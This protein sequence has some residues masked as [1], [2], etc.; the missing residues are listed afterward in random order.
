VAL[1]IFLRFV[2]SKNFSIKHIFG[3]AMLIVK[4][5]KIF[6]SQFK[7]LKFFSFTTKSTIPSIRTKCRIL[8]YVLH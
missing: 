8:L 4:D 6:L 2:V 7:L 3:R 1:I 5:L